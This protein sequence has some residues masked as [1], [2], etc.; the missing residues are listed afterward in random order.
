[1]SREM[2][3][4]H[5]SQM[6]LDRMF[7]EA[8]NLH[9]RGQ[10]SAAFKRFLEA[11]K[12]GDL[13]AQFMLG[14]LYSDGDGVKKDRDAALYWY[15]KAYRRGFG[16]AA[17]NIG[18]L[19]RDEGKLNRALTWFENAI[20]LG[21]ADANLEIAKIHLRKGEPTMAA[22]YLARLRKAPKGQV[23][24]GSIEEAQQLLSEIRRSQ[25]N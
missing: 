7:T 20:T 19:Y 3:T 2:R 14:N 16:P 18:V 25:R 6:E 9:D 22:E 13:G 17:S 5:Y 15:R 21:D 12:A 4:R 10:L 24:E 23:T 11:A 8:S 1:M